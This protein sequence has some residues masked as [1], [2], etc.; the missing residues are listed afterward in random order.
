[1]DTRDLGLVVAGAG[2]GAASVTAYQAWRAATERTV[3][4][5]KPTTLARVDAGRVIA[6]PETFQFKSGGDAKGVTDRLKGVKSWNPAA[7][8]KVMVFERA[9]GQQVIADG[10]QR[11]G[12]AQRLMA[13]GHAPI[14]LDAIVLREKDGWSARDVRAYAAIKNM[15]ESSGNPLDMAKVM[16][17]KSCPACSIAEAGSVKA[18]CR[19]P[20]KRPPHRSKSSGRTCA[21][22]CWPRSAWA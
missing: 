5:G 14:K 16:R 8:G 15:H 1:M 17:G 13:D 7:A 22:T 3:L 21:T 11:T 10:H 9:D 2:A 4:D 19:L 6:D 20:P 12:L 18:T